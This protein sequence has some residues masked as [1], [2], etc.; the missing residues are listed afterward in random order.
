MLSNQQIEEAHFNINRLTITPE[1]IIT[2]ESVIISVTVSNPGGQEG[3]YTVTLGINNVVEET[4][5]ITL[6]AGDSQIV[7]FTVSKDTAGDYEVTIDGQSGLFEVL[8]P[9]TAMTWPT[10]WGLIAAVVVI[11]AAIF[12]VARRRR[13]DTS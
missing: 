4:R 2:G 7:N 9:P 12:L 13:S 8:P 3:S 11:L 1:A 10:L 5:D 6:T